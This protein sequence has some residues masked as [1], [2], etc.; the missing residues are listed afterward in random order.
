MSASHPSSFSKTLYFVC[1]GSLPLLSQWWTSAHLPFSATRSG[2][3]VAFP[4]SSWR[5][6]ENFLCGQEGLHF[7]KWPQHTPSTHSSMMWYTSGP[8]L[9]G[10][11]ES[12][13]SSLD[14]GCTFVTSLSTS[15]VWK[16]KPC[17]KARKVPCISSSP[18]AWNQ[19][20]CWVRAKKHGEITCQNSAQQSRPGH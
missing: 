19:L 17:S 20:P 9:H 8:P 7:L 4:C 10:E 16:M 2:T 18:S 6:E 12:M 1:C 3:S 14:P 5:P 15:I 11:L 13:S